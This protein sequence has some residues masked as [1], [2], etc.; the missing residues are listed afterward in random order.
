MVIMPAHVIIRK[1]NINNPINGQKRIPKPTTSLQSP[2][3]KLFLYRARFKTNATF[4]Q[5]RV[6]AVAFILLIHISSPI[7][8]AP[9]NICPVYDK[10]SAYFC[11][12]VVVFIHESYMFDTVRHFDN[13]AA[14]LPF[15]PCD[16]CSIFY[17]IDYGITL[18]YVCAYALS[19]YSRCMKI[20]VC[21]ANNCIWKF[22][23]K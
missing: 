11:I 14:F 12:E 4:A 16:M 15:F 22:V 19:V 18:T 21:Y 23:G 13:E 20:Y 8:N 7:N 10:R 3:R 6:C 9:C 5:R 17:H 1:K 2:P